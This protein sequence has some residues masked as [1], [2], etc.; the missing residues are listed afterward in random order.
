MT[1]RPSVV[2]DR[3]NDII[4]TFTRSFE[5]A[6][7]L[8]RAD[9]ANAREQKRFDEESRIRQFD[10]EDRE[11]DAAIRQAAP[12]VTPAGGARAPAFPTGGAEPI[13]D[14]FA[15]PPVSGGGDL[16]VQ[17]PDFEGGREEIPGVGGVG[18]VTEPAPGRRGDEVPLPGGGTFSRSLEESILAAE[19]E[20]ETRRAADIEFDLPEAREERRLEERETITETAERQRE[21]NE[22]FGE[23]QAFRNLFPELAEI[24]N[25]DT[26]IAQGEILAQQQLRRTPTG[27]SIA[28]AAGRTDRGVAN[29]L[30]VFE[31]QLAAGL[32]AARRRTPTAAERGAALRTGEAI[33]F[34]ADV[35]RATI[36]RDA[37]TSALTAG[38]INPEQAAT[39]EQNVEQLLEQAGAGGG[40]AGGPL[41]E[42]D[43]AFFLENTVGTT[44][45]EQQAEWRSFGLDAQEI[46]QLTAAAGGR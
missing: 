15:V 20:R 27:A 9:Q 40:G 33:D 16:G 44:I 17:I 41:P 18:V 12:G 30:A 25:D 13:G 34:E 37:I 46:A 24:T 36:M 22:R 21:I 19:Q 28:S 26:V 42:A 7:N 2:P 39:M 38:T 32:S 4:S 43:L 11:F 8:V 5:R 31:R 10:I 23:A 6:R 35:D 29:V 3:D 14:A 1:F 45:E